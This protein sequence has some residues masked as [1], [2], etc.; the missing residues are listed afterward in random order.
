MAPHRSV[1]HVIQTCD[2]FSVMM[3]PYSPLYGAAGRELLDL[4]LCTQQSTN[5]EVQLEH[6]W[7]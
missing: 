4:M 3:I 1:R 5:T 2:G 7:D 6:D